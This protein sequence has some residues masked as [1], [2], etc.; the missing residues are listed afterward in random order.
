MSWKTILVPH[1]FS[2]SAKRTRSRAKGAG[3]A[4]HNGTIG[5]CTIDPAYQ[6]GPDA[7][8][9]PGNR[10][11]DQREAVCAGR[12][13]RRCLRHA[14][15]LAGR[16]HATGVVVLGSPVEEI[17]RAIHDQHADLVVMEAPAPASAPPGR[18]QCRRARR[19]DEQV[20]C[21]DPASRLAA[22]AAWPRVEA[23]LRRSSC[24]RGQAATAPSR[25][26][27]LRPDLDRDVTRLSSSAS[28]TNSSP[29]RADPAT[30][31]R[32]LAVPS[33]VA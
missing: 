20:R 11:A 25:R 22:R 23:R 6:L 13:P 30:R 29:R 14:A 21:D 10:R 31:C 33:G 16:R 3:G 19:A 26:R 9:V 8:I 12:A 1:D 17:N 28:V 4:G 18:R 2:A 7:V 32:S 27:R 24:L 15:R 5:C